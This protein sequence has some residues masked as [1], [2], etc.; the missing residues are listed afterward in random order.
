LLPRLE[1]EQWDK[2]KRLL[3]RP[4]TYSYLDRLQGKIQELPVAEEVREAVVA[5]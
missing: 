4:Q 2:F 3:Q 5:S 1:G